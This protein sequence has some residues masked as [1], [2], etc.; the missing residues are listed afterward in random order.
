M[1]N[2]QEVQ[3]TENS[4]LLTDLYQLT[5]AHNYWQ[6]G[7]TDRK[8][9]CQLFFRRAPYAEKYTVTAGLEAATNYIKNWNFNISDLDYLSTLT[10]PNGSP[11]FK[12]EFL[13]YLSNLQFSGNVKA[14]PEGTL[15]FPQQPLLRIE[16]PLIQAQLLE[17]PIMNAYSLATL[18]AT[19]AHR[20][21]RAA[22]GAPISEFGLRRA[23][24]PNGGLTASRAAYIGGINSTSNVLAGKRYGIPVLGTLSHS[25]IMSF[26]DEQQAFDL[27]AECM[28]DATVL[29]VDTYQTSEGIDKAINTAQKLQ[30]QG[31]NL[32]A[33]RLDSGDL[34]KLSCYAREKL[35]QA[36]LSQTKIMAS[37]NIDEHVIKSLR[38]QN[39]AIDAWGVGTKLATA[40][41]Q[42]SL[43]IAYKLSAIEDMPNQWRYC[44]KK[45]DTV[46][47]KSFA[48]RIEIYRETNKNKWQ[49]DVLYEQSSGV[50]KPK[51]NNS[52]YNI[53][54]N[55]IEN[56]E[57]KYSSPPLPEIKNFVDEQFTS[58]NH[59]L[60]K[61]EPYPIEIE[62]SL[63]DI[64][65]HLN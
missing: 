15:L 8:A 2:A 13:E 62:Q 59:W 14:A 22:G 34:A 56:G 60:K 52:G 41:G 45:S 35:N 24:G 29:L 11:R 32:A 36:G 51:Q 1:S 61:D 42:G 44:Y 3:C 10:W 37:G 26:S 30:Q 33:I 47:K 5:M 65:P 54:E 38:Q 9:C 6:L 23:Q 31:K 28:G 43:D 12:T 27:A 57:I 49:R 20:I 18:V 21:T 50:Q 19:K 55:I 46:G 63:S 25:W 64:N 4:A 16:A 58:W 7:Q 17:T 40:D 48:G 39:A 53:L